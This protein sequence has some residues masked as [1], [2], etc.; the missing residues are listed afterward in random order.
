MRPPIIWTPDMDAAVATLATGATGVAVG[1]AL[2]LSTSTIIN[3]A[4]V[5]GVKSATDRRGER[6]TAL[7]DDYGGGMS[8][9][10][11]MA[12]YGV[13]SAAY[14]DIIRRAPLVVKERRAALTASNR[15]RAGKKVA[16]GASKRNKSQWT[17]APRAVEAAPQLTIADMALRFL[18]R[19]YVG[20]YRASTVAGKAAAGMFVVS[21]RR[22]ASEAELL[23]FAYKQGFRA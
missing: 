17:G 15:E 20:C 12:K 18:Q 23:A 21:W 8:K 5:L 3:R 9:K 11:A 4:K 1:K 6:D 22:F 13:T 7:Y 16:A 19:K 14:D 10:D 2:G